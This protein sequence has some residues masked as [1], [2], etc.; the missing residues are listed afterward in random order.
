MHR[1]SREGK[2]IDDGIRGAS[3]ESLED[4]DN[5]CVSFQLP[6]FIKT[7]RDGEKVSLP[8]IEDLMDGVIPDLYNNDLDSP[9]DW[10]SLARRRS[11]RPVN[12]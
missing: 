10:Y 11:H 8:E 7:R 9:Y 3:S 1:H 12:R 5:R 2:P 4:I 6:D